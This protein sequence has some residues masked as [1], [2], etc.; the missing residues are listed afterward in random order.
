MGLDG[1]TC[2]ECLPVVTCDFEPPE[3][4]PRITARAHTCAVV[5]G[6]A[7]CV[8]RSRRHEKRL[9]AGREKTNL[10]FEYIIIQ[11]SPSG[12]GFFLAGRCKLACHM[13]KYQSP[14]RGTRSMRVIPNECNIYLEIN[15]RCAI[16]KK[17]A[18][19]GLESL[20]HF[21]LYEVFV[22]TLH[23]HDS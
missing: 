22:N 23:H 7:S 6:R 17:Q 14:S 3:N 11:G 1:S 4:V 9:S 15:W 2:S 12:S 19:F 10:Y 16:K 13:E 20:R 8:P 18:I 5:F 21:V